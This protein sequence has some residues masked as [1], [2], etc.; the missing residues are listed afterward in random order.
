VVAGALSSADL[1]DVQEEVFDCGGESVCP[2]QQDSVRIRQTLAD[3]LRQ[4]RP[5]GLF[6]LAGIEFLLQLRYGGNLE[7]FVCSQNSPRV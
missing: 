5:H 4:A 3:V 7:L 1:C 6:E 2:V